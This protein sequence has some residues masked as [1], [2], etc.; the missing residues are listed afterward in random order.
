MTGVKNT[1]GTV[2][3]TLYEQQSLLSIQASLSAGLK[4]ESKASVRWLVS[5]GRVAAVW[6]FHW[7]VEEE[8]V[9]Y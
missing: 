3:Y 6:L 5:G 9:D 7:I 8:E 2:Q 4:L 1:C